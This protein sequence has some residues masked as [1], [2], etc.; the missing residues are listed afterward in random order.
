MR[1]PN[2]FAVVVVLPLACGGALAEEAAGEWPNYRGPNHDG[3]SVEKGWSSAFPQGGAKVLWKAEV[4]TGFSSFAVAGGRVFT[5]GNSGDQDTVFALDAA[6][7]EVKWKHSYACNIDP[8][9]YEGGPNAT[10]TVEGGRVYTLSRDGEVFCLDAEKGS[11]VWGKKVAQETGAK[12]PDWGFTGSPLISGDLAI[13]NIGGKGTALKKAD[14]GIAWKSDGKAGYATPIPVALG[15]QKAVAIFASN[16]LVLVNPADGRELASHPWKTDWDVNASE[17]IVLGDKFFVAS[18]YNTGCALLQFAGGKFSVLWQNKNLLGQMSAGAAVQGNVYAVHGNS[19][20]GPKEVR[21]IDLATGAVK[22]KHGGLGLG[23]LAV[24]DGHLIVLGETGKLEIA[25]ASPA[26]Y[27][28][29]ASAQV[30]EGRCWTVPV[31]AGGRIYARNAKGAVV[32]IAVS[33][34]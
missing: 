10:P 2:I 12:R 26:G 30:L 23:T 19:H 1:V 27:Q 7:G 31:L 34:K 24:A 8:N 6:T 21:C 18:G 5:M 9:M 11:V 13:L 25:P 20:G 32:C 4:G 22:W 33:T 3:V 28:P 15:K 17:P 16:A 29:T 14:G